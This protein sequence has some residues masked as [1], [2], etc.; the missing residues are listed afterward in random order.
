MMLDKIENFSKYEF[1]NP[2]SSE[3]CNFWSTHE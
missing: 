3:V 2:L 1:M